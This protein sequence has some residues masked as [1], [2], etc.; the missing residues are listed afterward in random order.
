MG[1]WGYRGIELWDYGV[2]EYRVMG[3]WGYRGIGLW[4]YGVMGV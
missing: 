2:M 1:L 3:L 4:D